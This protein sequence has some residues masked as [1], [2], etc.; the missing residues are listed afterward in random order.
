[1]FSSLDAPSNCS[2]P[3]ASSDTPIGA[4]SIEFIVTLLV[5]SGDSAA[6]AAPIH[7]TNMSNDIIKQIFDLFFEIISFLL[8]I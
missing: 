1:M 6:A 2:A 4:S 5:S 7:N 3:P 8:N